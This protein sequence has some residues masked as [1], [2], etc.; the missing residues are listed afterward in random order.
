M[1][2]EVLEFLAPAPGKSFLDA[3]VGLGGHSAAIIQR[4]IPGGLLLG[5]D[6]DAEMLSLARTYFTDSGFPR[7]AWRLFHL[8]YEQMDQAA[9]EAGLADGFDGILF[10]L[11][12]SSPQI[13]QPG[14]GF[15][16]QKDGPLDFRFDVTQPLR[17]WDVV[18]RWTE[19]EI[20]RILRE[21]ADE[22]NATSI[23]RRIC[24]MRTASPIRSTGQLAAIVHSAIP[25]RR[26]TTRRDCST[27]TFQ[28][29]R[30]A[31]NRELEILEAALPKA[32]KLLKSDG[33]CLVLS[34]HSKED[35][36]AKTIFN[37]SARACRR[38]P[39]FEV[40]TRKPLGPSEAEMD[41]N[42]RAR[43]VRLRAIKRLRPEDPSLDRAPD[44][45]FS[46][47]GL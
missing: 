27:L 24:Q 26:K 3:T 47:G 2:A 21:Y 28:A 1:T 32:L 30:I 18:N 33:V 16:F 14:R 4:I 20:R 9:R 11:G 7:E 42:P 13:D 44:P 41:S 5:L 31:V 12:V 38:N 22:P 10:D 45:I 40:L 17:G 25:A 39:Q 37:H 36:I 19:K 6:R 46:A 35:H 8:S 23:A 29:I 43:S 34:Y 15:S